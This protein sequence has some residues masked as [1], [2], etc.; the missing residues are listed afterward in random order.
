MEM[1]KGCM[2]Q[3]RDVGIDAIN[4]DLIY[5][6]PGQSLDDLSKTIETATELQP[7]RIALFDYAHMLQ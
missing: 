5:G 6:F 1:I 4:F 2:T 7:N 3:L